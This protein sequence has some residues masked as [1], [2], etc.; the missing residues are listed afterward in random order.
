MTSFTF[1]V[2]LIS[3]AIFAAILVA[4]EVGSKIGR[5][6]YERDPSATSGTSAVDGAIFGLMGLLLAF[7]FAG[8]ASRFDT[9][10]TLVV[11]EANTIGTAYLR[12]D[13]LPAEA[14]VKLKEDFRQYLDSRLAIYRAFPDIALVKKELGRSAEIQ[15]R[16]WSGAIAATRE[17]SNPAVTS[18]VLSNINDMIDITLTRAAALQTHPPAIIFVVL[19]VMVLA[20]ALLA[21]YNMS[22]AKVRNWTYRITFAVLVTLALYLIFDL[23]FPRFGLIRVDAF[24]QILVDVRNTMK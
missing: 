24:D 6:R 20:S 21:G 2:V 23:E 8:A 14:Q 10:R 1:W 18:L 11:E 15:G 19:V 13:L 17:V 12:L 16:I 4:L 5:I 7:T 9:R 3:L 22:A